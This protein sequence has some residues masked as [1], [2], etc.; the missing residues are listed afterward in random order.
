MHPFELYFI[1]DIILEN[2][3]L[4]EGTDF[5]VII[6]WGSQISSYRLKA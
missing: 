1:L 3:E 4:E 5:K 2:S 6:K